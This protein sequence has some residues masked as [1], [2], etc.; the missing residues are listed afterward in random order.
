[1][2]LWRYPLSEEVVL[3]APGSDPGSAFDADFGCLGCG[4][5]HDSREH[6][7]RAFLISGWHPRDL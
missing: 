4:R 7:I 2:G 6:C 1:M 5:R 3:V